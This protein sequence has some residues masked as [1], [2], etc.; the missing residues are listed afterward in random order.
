VHRVTRRIKKY[1]A[2]L[3]ILGIK[4][5]YHL[6][7]INK[8]VFLVITIKCDLSRIKREIAYYIRQMMRCQR[9]GTCL[10]CTQCISWWRIHEVFHVYATHSSFAETRCTPGCSTAPPIRNQR[11]G[12]CWQPISMRLVDQSEKDDTQIDVLIKWTLRE[13]TRIQLVAQG[14]V[15]ALYSTANGRV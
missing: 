5:A 8:N 6:A 3:E 4:F 1:S 2:T 15:R 10:C 7:V 9:S 13:S 12:R 14:K 11:H